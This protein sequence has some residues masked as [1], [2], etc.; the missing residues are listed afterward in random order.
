M[1]QYTTGQNGRQ[2]G[3]R[4]QKGGAKQGLNAT[5]GHARRAVAGRSAAGGYPYTRQGGLIGVLGALPG[6]KARQDSRCASQ[7]GRLVL[8][9]TVRV[10]P[11]QKAGSNDAR[12]GGAIESLANSD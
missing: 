2:Q 1:G 7:R 9:A 6:K 5:A 8:Q 3:R 12:R 4:L 10:S 11:Q